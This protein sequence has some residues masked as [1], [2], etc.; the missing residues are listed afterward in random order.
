MV[1]RADIRPISVAMVP[2]SWLWLNSNLPKKEKNDKR[3]SKGRI[4][5]EC[6]SRCPARQ[7]YMSTLDLKPN[8]NWAGI[9]PVS[10]LSSSLS[11]FSLLRF[12]HFMPVGSL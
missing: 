3:M 2:V 8:K 7:T 11:V 12:D 4:T 9:D 10:S 5:S 1:P 6:H